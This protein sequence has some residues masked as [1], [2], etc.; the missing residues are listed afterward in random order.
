MTENSEES[1]PLTLRFSNIHE[2]NIIETIHRI[3][4]YGS[5]T[6]YVTNS[7]GYNEVFQ[8]F[9]TNNALKSI[10][11]ISSDLSR[12]DQIR[13]LFL[14]NSNLFY[15]HKEI[16]DSDYIEWSLTGENL[17]KKRREF[18]SQIDLYKTYDNQNH[19]I[20]KLLI[21]IIDYLIHREHFPADEK[22]KLE[23][24]FKRAIEEKN[25]LIYFIKAYTLTNNFHHI[26]NKH[27]ALYIY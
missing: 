18:R 26:L 14:K 8:L 2:N 24:Y 22:D 17:I 25:Y 5:I 3:G 19:L 16:E 13:K 7:Y 27:L 4:P 10:E 15:S 12:I 9:L 11:N 1:M 21:E 6:L 23:F 20:T